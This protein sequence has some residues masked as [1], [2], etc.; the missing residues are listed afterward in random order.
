[1][2]EDWVR[3][4]PIVNAMVKEMLLDISKLKSLGW[5]PKYNSMEAVRLTVKR[6]IGITAC[7]TS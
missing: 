3:A 1:M 4:I 2:D 5:R 6:I 7:F